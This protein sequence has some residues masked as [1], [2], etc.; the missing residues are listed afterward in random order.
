MAVDGNY[1][2]EINSPMGTR[3]GSLVLKTDG[4]SLTGSLSAEQG[5]QALEDGKVSGDD[6]SFKAGV[7]TPM[8][9]IQLAFSGSVSGENISGNVQAGD[10]GTFPF[11][12]NRSS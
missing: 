8:G 6:F 1:S 7:S 12:G 9:N 5:E 3:P 10:F 11:Q 4:N 2:I